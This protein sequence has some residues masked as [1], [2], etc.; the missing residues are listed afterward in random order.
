MHP[1]LCCDSTFL[2]TESVN[3]WH[4][5]FGTFLIHFEVTSA[6]LRKRFMFVGL[7]S[8]T[9]YTPY[10]W[11]TG[12]PW[13]CCSAVWCRKCELHS[14]GSGV[15]SRTDS[16]SRSSHQPLTAATAQVR[17]RATTE[18]RPWISRTCC[19]S[20]TPSRVRGSQVGWLPPSARWSVRVSAQWSAVI[21]PSAADSERTVHRIECISA[22]P[23]RHSSRVTRP[24]TKHSLW[25]A[26]FPGT[27]TAHTEP[28]ETGQCTTAASWCWIRDPQSGIFITPQRLPAFPPRLPWQRR[29]PK[30][31]ALWILSPTQ[32]LPAAP[33]LLRLP[34]GESASLPQQLSPP[35]PR[36]QTFIS[37]P[38]AVP[39]WT[40]A[41][42]VR[43][44][45]FP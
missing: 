16:A 14:A 23:T 26:E 20:T 11:R 24:P 29:V 17:P 27:S 3:S 38:G 10:M 12:R 39:V 19:C 15:R 32:G 1:L 36:I 2:L 21:C 33:P 7:H 44:S 40:E 4:P 18:T 9:G 41:T 34:P 28:T 45:A 35:A 31:R 25:R 6:S 37:V 13:I 30:G 8:R 22:I 5:L 42:L 43:R